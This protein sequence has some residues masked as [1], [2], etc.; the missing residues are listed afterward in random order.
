M[1]HSKTAAFSQPHHILIYRRPHMIAI[2]NQKEI[3]LQLTLEAFLAGE[4]TSIRAAA[5]AHNVN[6][7]TLSR[8]VNGGLTHSESHSKRQLL[9]ITQEEPTERFMLQ[10]HFI[11]SIQQECCVIVLSGRQDFQAETEKPV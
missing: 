2:A 10:L 9:S 6:P 5:I 1:N 8:R 7:S 4:F 3:S 11:A